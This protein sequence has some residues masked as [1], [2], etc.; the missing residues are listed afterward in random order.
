MRHPQQILE[1]IVEMRKR[2]ASLNEIV[3]AVSLPKT[4]IWHHVNKVKILPGHLSE[5]KLK[6]GGS[7]K[8]SI[9]EFEKSRDEA[10]LLVG[11]L[12]RKEKILIG[13]ALYW[14]EGSKGDFSISNTDPNLIKTFISCLA[15]LGI[16]N[17]RLSLSLRIF[18]DLDTKKVCNY[19]SRIT[20]IP[21]KEIK[22]VNILNGKKNGKLPYGMCRLR[23]I[24][25]RYL[26][27]LFKSMK[28]CVVNQLR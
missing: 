13:M 17:K 14:G 12:N 18:E 7:L 23:V 21:K 1:K 9:K 15:E 24:K 28:E 2:G 27:K 6:R 26:L 16:S 5:W 20:G 10:G 4:T 8:K 22:Y 11:T 3:D 19:W 25:P